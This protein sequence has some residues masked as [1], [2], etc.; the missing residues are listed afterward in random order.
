[1]GWVSMSLCGIAATLYRARGTKPGWWGQLK[2]L[3]AAIYQIWT[4]PTL[5]ETHR[6]WSHPVQCC[7]VLFV[8]L[9]WLNNIK[10]TSNKLRDCFLPRGVRARAPR[11]P[12][13][14]LSTVLSHTNTHTHK[15]PYSHT[16]GSLPRHTQTHTRLCYVTNGG[17]SSFTSLVRTQV[18]SC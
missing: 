7:A 4:L 9:P 16:L 15:T 13:L 2:G 1:M 11:S 12:T 8:P 3:W 10:F 6:S 5:L 18:S 17:L 14:T